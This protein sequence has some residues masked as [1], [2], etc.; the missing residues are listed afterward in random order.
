MVNIA[1]PL[2]LLS[3]D[4]NYVTEW[5]CV[6]DGESEK[7]EKKG[8][9]LDDKVQWQSSLKIDLITN[10]I[11]HQSFYKAHESVHH[12]EILSPP[13]QYSFV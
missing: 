6:G 8:E 9:E 3:E 7:E 4:I 12:P 13:P 2:L 1:A 11:G 5:Q 10:L